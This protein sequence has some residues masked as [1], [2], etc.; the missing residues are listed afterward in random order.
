MPI[1]TAIAAALQAN[2]VPP[3][4]QCVPGLMTDLLAKIAA[5]MSVVS[6]T[7]QTSGGSGDS[8]AQQALQQ[9]AI[10]LSTANQALAAA[11]NVR[12]VGTPIPIGTGDST[13][14]ISWSPAFADTDYEVRGTYYRAAGNV[15]TY[16]NF[17]VVD[18]S[19]TT[20]SCQIF[21]ENT[22]ANTKFAWV[23]QALPD[24]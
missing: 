6:S 22:P 21:F 3:D 24:S 16:F 20:T 7:T 1:N 2:Q 15:G 11:P 4:Q 12:S 17:I 5:Y 14:N 19:R 9:S 13:L 10:A 23:A 8:V 18:G